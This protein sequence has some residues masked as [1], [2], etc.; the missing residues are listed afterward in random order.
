MKPLSDVDAYC[1]HPSCQYDP[2][3]AR[4]AK[5]IQD[6]RDSALKEADDLRDALLTCEG[7][8]QEARAFIQQ[9]LEKRA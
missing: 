6:E 8:L 7:R 5:V 1:E 4:F 2:E 9:L 3:W